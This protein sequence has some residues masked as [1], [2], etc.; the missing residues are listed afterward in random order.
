MKIAVVGT[1]YVGLVLGACLAENGND[2]TCIDND[3]EK[4]AALNAG[5]VP[6]HEKFLPELLQKH[7]GK[8]LKFSGSVHDAVRA[9]LDPG[10]PQSGG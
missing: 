2:V 1:G 5:V 4:L 6:I 3:E 7:R 9:L 10:R 8:R